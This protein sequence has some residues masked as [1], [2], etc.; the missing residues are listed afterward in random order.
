MTLSIRAHM[1]NSWLRAMRVGAT[2]V[3]ACFAA[4]ASPAFAQSADLVVNQADSPDPGPAGG[5]FTYTIRIDN[6][7]PDGAVGVNFSDTLP[8][9][10]TFVSAVPTAGSCGAPSGGVLTCSLGDLVFLANATVTI[11]VV[12]PNPG[13]FTNTATATSATPDPNPSNNINVT[14]DTTAVNASDMTLTIV[15]APDPVAAGQNYTYTITATNNGPQP[16]VSQTVSFPV[17]TGACIRTQPTGGASWSCTGS[18]AFPLCSGTITCVRNTTL[19]NGASAPN[20]TVTAV[21]NVS[22]SI[23]GSFTVT[24]P[25]P[26]G[27][28]TDNTVTATTTVNPGSDVSITKAV[29]SSTVGVGGTATFTLTPRFN[30]GEPP[31]TLP[32]NVITVTDTMPAGLSLNSMPTGTGWTCAVSGVPSPVFPLA[33]PQTIQCT[34]PGPYTG[35]TNTIMG[36][37]I[38]MVTTVTAVGAMTNTATIAA[39]EF[40]PVPANNTA[41]VGVTGSNDAD[42]SMTKTGPTFPVV[43]GQE[44]QY[45]LRVRN[46]GPAAVLTGQTVTAT[47]TIQAGLNILALPSGTGWTC[48]IV[49]VPSPVYPLAGPQTVQCTRPGPLAVS[50]TQPP[51]ITIRVASNSIG[52]VSN[53]GCVA[54][55]GTGPSDPNVNNNCSTPGN[56]T[57]QSATS[58]ADLRV[59]SKTGSPN[60]VRAGENLTYV[61]TVDNN[62]PFPAT[63]VIVTDTVGNLVNVGGLQSATASQGSC[64]PTGPINGTSQTVNCNLG[65]LNAGATATVTIVVRP[66]VA[67]SGTR[68]NNASI[69]SADVA[70]PDR[71]NNQLPNTGITTN[72]TALVDMTLAKIDNPDPA[73]AGTPLTYVLTATNAGPSTASAVKVTD[74]LP[75]NVAFLSATAAGGGSC[76]TPPVNSVGGTVTC[77]WAT[78]ATASAQTATII[79][80]PLTGETSVTNTAT[81]ETTTEETSTSNNSATSTTAIN[82]ASVDIIVNKVDTVDPVAVG[83]TTGYVVTITNSGPSYAT[84]VTLVDTFPDGGTPTATFSYQGGLTITPTG[85]GTC[86]EP[87]ANATTGTLSCGFPGLAAGQSIVVRYNMRAE[88]I[89]AG[90][91]GTTFN[92]AV[93][94][95]TEPETQTGNNTTVHST[96]SRQAADL[97]IVKTAP[98]TVIPGQALTWNL[99]VTN[100]GPHSSTGAIV[101]DTLPTGVTF[102]SASPGCNFA[103]GVVTCTLGTL[104]LGASTLLAINVTVNQPY[105]GATPLVNSAT[106]ATVNEIDIVPGNNTSTAATTITPQADLTVSKN[107]STGTPAIGGTVQFTI[108]AQNLGPN[109]AVAAQVLDVLPA[110]YQYVTHTA[111]TGSYNSGTGVWTLNTFANGASATL[112]ITATV[113]PG[114]PYLNTATIS[115]TTD[116][117]N[118]NNNTSSANTSPVVVSSLAVTKTDNSTTYVPGGTGTYVVVVT[119]GGP[120]TASNV[121]VTDTLP[122]GV[123]L[124]GTVTCVPAGAGTNCGSVSGTAGQSAFGATGA[125]ILAGAGNS[126]TFSVPVAY[127]SSLTANPLTN[128][129][130]ATAPSSPNATA[131]DDSAPAPQVALTVTKTDGSATYTPGGTATY[132]VTVRN[133]GPSNASSI[134]V[135]D[136]LPT[137]VT[138]T[139]AA[140]CAATGVATC[141]TVTGSTGQSSFGTTGAT[142]GAATGD[143]LVF[144]VPVAF[145]GNMTA[146]PLVN[147]ATATN[148][149]TSSTASGSDTNTLAANVSLAV[150][151]TDGSA[152]YTP[153]GTGTYTITVTNTGV[154]TANGVTVTDNLP[155]G[156]TLT[157]TVTCVPAGAS[158]C[159]TVTGTAG[160]TSLGTTGASIVAGAGNAIVFTAPVAFAANLATDPLQNTA[161]ATDIP[162]GASGSS[163]D[164]NGRTA[165]VTLVVAKTDNATSYV[166]GGTGTYVITVSNTGTSDALNVTVNDPLPAGVTLTGAATCAPTGVAICG[167]VT[168]STGG[169]TLGTTGGAIAAGAGNALVFTAPVA[170]ASNMTSNPLVNTATATDLASG[171]TA[172]GND[173]NTLSRNVALA[174]TKTDGQ[175]TYVPGS[176]ATYVVVVTNTGITD[177]LGVSVADTLPAG[178]TLTGA[179]TCTASGTATC[180]TINGG[181]PRTDYFSTTGSTI[182]AGA[183]NSL[184]F[185]LPVEFAGNMTA[186]PVVNVVTVVDTPSGAQGSASDSNTLAATSVSLAKS[187]VPGTIDMGGTAVLTIQIGNPNAGPAVLTA[188]FTDPMPAGVTITSGNTGTCTGVGL[189]S[190]SVSLASG[191]TIPMGGCTI[192]VTVTSSTPGTVTNT[193]SALQ[194]SLGAAPAATAP[195]TVNGGGGGGVPPTLTKT[196]SPSTINA[197]GTA[198]LTI[199]IGNANAAAITLIAD[200]VD[201][202]PTGVTTTSGNSGTCTGVTVAPASITMASGT[203]VPPGGCTIVV[204]ITSSTPGVVV[205]TTGSLSTSAGVAPPASAPIAVVAGPIPQADLSVVK[206]TTSTSVQ[207]GGAIT[208]TIVAS[209]AGPSAVVGA[210]VTDTFSSDLT[211]VTWTCVASAGSS[212]PASGAG[213]I[214]A[215]VN[216]LV[217]GTATFTV[218]A[219]VA[220]SATGSVTNTATIAPPPGVIDPDPSDDTSTVVTPIGDAPVVDLGIVK[221][222]NGTFHAGQVGASYTIVVTN[223]GNVPTSGEVVVSELV[224]P[225]L[226]ATSMTGPG[227]TCTQPAGPCKRSDPLA[228]GASYPPITLVVNV[229]DDPP[230]SVTNVATVIGGGDT[231]GG[232]TSTV[233]TPIDIRPPAP[234]HPDPTEPIPVDSPIALLLAALLLAAAGARHLRGRRAR[235]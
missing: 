156:V 153:G 150:I 102:V 134:T 214:N 101:T 154:S 59:L 216:L 227:W 55:T 229:A 230:S 194:T 212:C 21:A 148:V 61:I 70:D 87:A 81:V 92:R 202:M 233:V 184:T 25:L 129:V 119:N 118:P 196:I 1:R 192:V 83:Q 84:N 137:G 199:G 223:H 26:D 34:R 49:G 41:S 6:N 97:G 111:S 140:T 79:V 42:L 200:F 201:P 16:A 179:V 88:S 169:T 203:S 112:T 60:P 131:S 23:T 206:T 174:I 85:A 35:G 38:T 80:R 193:T 136:T 90:T 5:V 65:T 165:N 40:D 93:V 204:S 208:Y 106:V 191:S 68:T 39:P 9:G 142:L 43:P 54:L 115:S 108:T 110:G 175:T 17:P 143:T 27:D 45:V 89:A 13:V 71:S 121:S 18:G 10:S 105:N 218:N 197:G 96:T 74:P 176:T 226:T 166:P 11:Q 171:A 73:Q 170:F 127:A 46:L 126:L 220:G 182:P 125:T 232:D 117:P 57:T 219:T 211:N 173:S 124:N 145:A 151:K 164:S 132:T 30:F 147:T 82:A 120:S 95:A 177:A 123:T 4:V 94:A 107:V 158:A 8:P 63:N 221:T 231:G 183:G 51:D 48:S 53:T 104:N 64:S 28:P 56:V 2:A 224:P 198:T 62:G 75:T 234:P 215:S 15:D 99:T 187:I 149:P 44:F 116:D 86:T 210:T 146:N 33:G 209:N 222:A 69:S 98:A 155:A 189:N 138:L 228:P 167:T 109:A 36:S 122:T 24:S 7:G 29:N 67:L 195:L 135:T 32:P 188:P 12:L 205:N 3:F 160:G 52:T 168:G 133:T 66:L 163:T 100:N 130:T 161:T 22:G 190:T 114:G 72:V 14:E 157:G 50:T 20:I 139:A 31:G 178:V 103:A 172:S 235:R 186:N 113:L 77:T 185:T 76:T 144:T 91:S 162:T 141:G 58:A 213:N 225:G 180:G 152:T 78:I 207:P 128:T 159:G 37:A 181:L 217:G 19:A 47:D